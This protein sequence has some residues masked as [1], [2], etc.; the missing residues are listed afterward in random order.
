MS[1]FLGRLAARG[2]GTLDVVRPRVLSLYE[3]DRRT[4]PPLAGQPLA[5]AHGL[6]LEPDTDPGEEVSIGVTPS[7]SVEPDP[8]RISRVIPPGRGGPDTPDPA[9]PMAGISA[10]DVQVQ[11]TTSRLAS[12]GRA[13]PVRQ[14]PPDHRLSPERSSP[15]PLASLA[16]PAGTTPPP[17]PIAAWPPE[18]APSGFPAVLPRQSLPRLHKDSPAAAGRPNQTEALIPVRDQHAVLRSARDSGQVT[19]EPLDVGAS[20]VT[21]SAPREARPAAFE[22]ETRRIQSAPVFPDPLPFN[23]IPVTPQ[24]GTPL[25][26]Q[27]FVGSPSSASSSTPDIRITVGRVDV[28]AV[29]PEAPVR[30]APP[31]RSRPSVSLDDYLKRSNRGP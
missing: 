7:R 4:A 1:D 16:S 30:R 24:P 28:R 6:G 12:E 14:R 15:T 29:F 8:A 26:G 10:G 27:P 3:P 31:A 22:P 25:A 9:T 13:I 20:H 23:A 5:Q 11:R 17:P 2:L 21:L 19:P 18:T